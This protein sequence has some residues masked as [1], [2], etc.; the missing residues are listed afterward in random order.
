M[1]LRLMKPLIDAF[2]TQTHSNRFAEENSLRLIMCKNGTRK[3]LIS[4]LNSVFVLWSWNIN[5]QISPTIS[6]SYTRILIF[7]I[8]QA[9]KMKRTEKKRAKKKMAPQ[10]LILLVE[11]VSLSTSTYYCTYSTWTLNSEHIPHSVY[12]LKIPPFFFS[13]INDTSTFVCFFRIYI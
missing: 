2:K 8:F 4:Y 12:I 11:R 6:S 5:L 13:Y 9:N 7:S 3:N 10:S 1:L